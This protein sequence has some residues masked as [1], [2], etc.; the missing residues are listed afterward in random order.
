MFSFLSASS[1]KLTALFSSSEAEFNAGA[2]LERDRNCACIFVMFESFKL[3]YPYFLHPT[4][5]I[6][7]KAPLASARRAKTFRPV[8]SSHFASPSSFRQKYYVGFRRHLLI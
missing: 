5:A 7:Q 1:S 4:G 2:I 3:I 8:K 6:K